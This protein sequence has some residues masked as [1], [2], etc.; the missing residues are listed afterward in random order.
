MRPLLLF[1]PGAGAPSSHPWMQSWKKILS[2][3]G[4]VGT[5][6]Y[7]YMREGRKR[8]DPL[9]QLI[10]AHREAL[11]RA[12]ERYRPERTILVGK[13]MGGR[14]GCHV[15]LEEKLA[16]LIC[17]GYPLCAMGDRAKLR[18][19]VLRALTTPILFVQGSRDSLCPLDLLERVRAEMKAPNFLHVVE[20]GDHSLR[21]SKRQLQGSNQT[22]EDV[23][24][25]VFQSIAEFI[26]GLPDKTNR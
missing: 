5:F 14:I 9:P 20:T 25:R 15:S 21:V 6:D 11:N 19:Q 4:E 18:D 8:P 2:E 26:A 12:R 13:S 22:Q 7:G 17:L 23:D 16:G 10:A 3:I 1:A 24:Q